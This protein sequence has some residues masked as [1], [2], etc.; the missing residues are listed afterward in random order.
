[1]DTNKLLTVV[2][3]AATKH[4]FQKRKTGESYIV[5]PIQV[6]TILTSAGITDLSI[7]SAA[8]LHD[9]VEDTDTTFDELEALFG[10][11][12]TN[13]VR[14]ATDD[15]SLDK[16][17]RKQLQITHS[18][19]ISKGGKLIKYADKIH[20]MSNIVKAV[21]CPFKPYEVAQGYCVWGMKVCEA[22]RGINDVLDNMFDNILKGSITD[23]NGDT[24]PVLPGGDL[25]AFLLHYYDLIR[26]QK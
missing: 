17:T 23:D 21:P 2:E 14:E 6:S 10:A 16:V 13:Y 25:D 20:N 7:I 3:F 22:F 19:T 5:H 4:Q 11:E 18:K 24:Y 12:I 1:M 9:T 26:G 15:K 8:I